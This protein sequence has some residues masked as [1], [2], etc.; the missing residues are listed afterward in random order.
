MPRKTATS[1]APLTFQAAEILRYFCIVTYGFL[2]GE[3]TFD[4]YQQ[5]IEEL[6]FIDVEGNLWLIGISSGEWYR[7]VGTDWV[8]GTP[9]GPLTQKPVSKKQPPRGSAQRVQAASEEG[10]HHPIIQEFLRKA[11]DSPVSS[12]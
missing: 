4:H 11:N 2:T 6:V 7:K 3:L 9:Y 8:L 12:R 1:G 5:A 10:I